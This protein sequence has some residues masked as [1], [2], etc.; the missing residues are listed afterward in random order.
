TSSTQIAEVKRYLDQLFTIKDLGPARYF[1]GL[2]IARASEGIALTQSKYV[3]DIVHDLKL[4]EARS[5]ATPLPPGFKLTSTLDQPLPQPAM[6]RRL[7]GRLLYL[8]FTR[9]DISHTVQQL[10]QFV[11]SPC[12]NHWDAATHVVKYLKGSPQKGFFFPA[13]ISSNLVAYC[14]TDWA[15]CPNTR[16][17][18]AGYCIFLGKALISWKTKKQNIV[19]RSTAEAEYR[20]MGTTSCELVWVA[21]LLQD[22]GIKVY[23]PIPFYYDNKAAMH[24]VSN[25]VFH[26]R[27]KHLEIDC[28]LVRNYYKFGF[29]NPVSVYSKDQLADIFTRPLR[30]PLF[31]SFLS[32]LGLINFVAGP[33]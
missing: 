11:Q 30:G 24:I 26:E 12:K 3:Q 19:S 9:P 31:H 2:E 28:R 14:D 13:H 29:L 1:L 32:K 7:V 20:A 23:C 17:S 21:A 6:Y 22:L 8:N 33:A 10:S 25:P 5:T 4:T 18:L 27:T 16:K 15:F